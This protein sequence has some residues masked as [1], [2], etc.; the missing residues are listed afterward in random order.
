MGRDSDLP[1]VSRLRARAVDLPLSR[2]V[3]TSAGTLAS[4]PM[5]LLDLQTDDGLVGHSY[6]RCYSHRLLRG[7]RSVLEDFAELIEA[8]PAGPAELVAMLGAEFAL[9]GTTGL[10]GL[11]VSG[12]DLCAWDLAAQRAGLP[13]CQLLREQLA[14]ERRS[15]YR[16]TPPSAR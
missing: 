15:R 4:T 6:L 5:V 14:H 2:P 13:L 7:L 12:I 8:K 1:R 11:A 3:H 9:V 10:V 16:P